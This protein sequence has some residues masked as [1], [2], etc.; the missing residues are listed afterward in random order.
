MSEEKVPV[1]IFELIDQAASGFVQEGT[2][3]LPE[4][5]EIRAPS[6]RAVLRQ[7]V[8]R[9]PQ[10]ATRNL[11]IRY[12]YGC[13]SIEVEEQ[14]KRGWE[15]NAQ[16]DKIYFEKGRLT[17][18]REGS[19]IGLYDYLK[20]SALNEKSD[21]RVKSVQPVWREVIPEQKKLDQNVDLFAEADA[22]A[23]LK[24]ELVRG[25]KDGRILYDEDKLEALCYFKK[26]SAETAHGR[27]NGLIAL[28]KADPRNFLTEVKTYLQEVALKI[29]HGVKLDVITLEPTGVRYLNRDKMILAYPG[30]LKAEERSKKL[31]SHF[32]STAGRLDYEEFLTECRAQ[33]E[34][35]AAK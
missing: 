21:Y 31:L 24:K 25:E 34:K 15:P 14:K 13:E 1:A 8:M 16:V 30:N 3:R 22:I 32:L 35:L 27:L 18:A 29:E 23:Y 10:D 6:T 12:I 7:S 20:K 33:E 11:K 28:A 19:L 9:H 17:V 26:V 2:E 5:I 4:P